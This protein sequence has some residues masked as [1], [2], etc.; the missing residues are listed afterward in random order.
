M[1]F[2]EISRL[3]ISK[4]DFNAPTYSS[5]GPEGDGEGMFLRSY[6]P[7]CTVSEEVAGAEVNQG[8]EA[9]GLAVEPGNPTGNAPRL[10]F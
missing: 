3:E 4:T 2:N 5:G 9:A 7:R 10:A 1:K 8:L 6:M